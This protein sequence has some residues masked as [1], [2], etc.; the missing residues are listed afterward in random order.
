MKFE[1]TRVK[2]SYRKISGSNNFILGTKNLLFGI[3]REFG[4]ESYYIIGLMV[5]KV[6]QLYYS[7]K[8]ARVFLYIVH[9]NNEE[10]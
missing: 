1:F 2:S 3:S 5:K 10:G 7:S 4:I 8:R 9:I 6:T